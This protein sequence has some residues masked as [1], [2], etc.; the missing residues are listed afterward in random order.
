MAGTRQQFEAED[1]KCHFGVRFDPREV[2]VTL[3]DPKNR[4]QPPVTQKSMLVHLNGIKID[5]KPCIIPNIK[6]DAPE[7]TD[8]LI[9][10]YE[11]ELSK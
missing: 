9:I 6:M 10:P 8:L 2:Q 1:K 4:G 3:R 7:H 11:R 5:F